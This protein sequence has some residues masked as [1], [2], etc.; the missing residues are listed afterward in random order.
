MDR[1]IDFIFYAV[2]IFISVKDLK[3][4]IIPDIFNLIIILLGIV[5]IIFLGGD[6]EKSFIGMGVFPIIFIL[7]YG[8]V[9]DLLKKDVIGFGDIKLMGAAGFFL[10]YSGIYNLIILYNTIFTA[11]LVCMLP[12]LLLGKIKRETEIPFAPF[13]S[14]GIIFWSFL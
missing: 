5:K 2:L 3:E 8:Y 14:L 12:L 6:F 10:E 9:S 13:I 1:V 7:I 4:K 11:A